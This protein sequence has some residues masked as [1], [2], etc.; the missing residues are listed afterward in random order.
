MATTTTAATGFPVRRPVVPGPRGGKTYIPV[1]QRERLL[2]GAA[3]MVAEGGVRGLR[4]KPVA[5]RAGMSPKTFYDLF[6]DCE[7]CFLALFDRALEDVARV[8]RPVYECER[9]WTARVRSGLGTLLAYLDTDPRACDLLFVQALGAGPRVLERRTEVLDVL[10]RVI[11]EGR[12][13]GTGRGRASQPSPLTAE[14]VV[15]AAFTVI[16]TRVCQQEAGSLSDLLNP[17]MATIVLPYR[18][19]AAAQRELKR[20]TAPKKIP[21]NSPL[22][23]AEDPRAQLWPDPLSSVRLL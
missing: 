3:E 22:V 8:V 7:D 12:E 4:A 5:A 6:A 10:A 18:G 16:H 23:Q 19:Q 14:S 20:R 9:E 11:D 17:L 21:S 13:A 2:D 15:G 1:V